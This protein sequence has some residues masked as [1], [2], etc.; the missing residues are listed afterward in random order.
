MSRNGSGTYSL[1]AGNPVTTGTTISST[2]ANNTLND[3]ASALTTSIA[4]DG[5]TVPV[6]N[7]PMGG[8]IHTNVGNAAA[9]T[10]YA[11]AGDVQDG[12][13]T[14]LT[15][16]SGTDTIT[17]IGPISMTAYATGQVLHFVAAGNVVNA[18]SFV[19][20]KTYVIL[21]VGT[22]DFTLIGAS[23]NTVGL[24]FT[25]TGVGTGSGTATGGNISTTVTLNVNSIGAKA[26]TKIN[27]APL[28]I[29]DIPSGAA[30][31]VAYDGTKFQLQS[32]VGVTSFS[33]GATG[34]TP[35]TAT[36]GAVTLAGV[37]GKLN[38]GT[39]ALTATIT[40]VSRVSNVS[41]ITTSGTHGFVVG[42]YV[43]VAAV[44]NTGFNGNFTVTGTP[45]SSSFTYAQTAA[46]VNPAV[47]DTGTVTD[48][49][50]V[51][52][53]TNVTGILYP[54]FGGT[55]TTT[56]P[57]GNLV[58]GNTTSAVTTVAPASNGQSVIVTAGASTN[59][60]SFVIGASYTI[61]LVGTTSFTS[62][63]ASANTVGVSFVATGVGSGTGTA[64][65]NTFSTGSSIASA[66][67]VAST[68]GT[69][70]AFTNIPSWAKKIT[71]IFFEVSVSGSSQMIVQIGN[72]TYENT[73]YQNGIGGVTSAAVVSPYG[74]SDGFP[75]TA[76]GQTGGSNVSGTMTLNLI[77]TSTY[78][79][80]VNSKMTSSAT[81]CSG[82]AYK[83]S[84]SGVIDRL[85]ITTSGGSQ[86]FD[87]G[88][89]NIF[90]E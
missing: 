34:L 69:A 61:T 46:D 56:L 48:L 24:A 83:T 47:L 20:G 55:G 27:G 59:A 41:T 72:G 18:G 80:T 68:S 4:Y 63:G 29:G 88:S 1:P 49:S 60:G 15:G 86:T 75:I 40:Q 23:A 50:Y 78:I 89:I 19:I 57:K 7:L 2:W 45:S 36:N 38:G 62:I 37:L 9:R 25:A 76:T 16:V 32:S 44:T 14:Y 87:N 11:S 79:A 6:A 3:M 67:T 51:N 84:S 54:N 5:Q 70:I 74:G 52:L 64:T 28:A 10:N 22:T 30:V 82:A 53:A 58:V 31:A 26:I 17:A 8:N 77:S 43:T 73:G 90:Y 12:T 71:I 35:S 33:A 42:D 21:T 13:L 66:T 39:G 81:F 85:Q 65:L